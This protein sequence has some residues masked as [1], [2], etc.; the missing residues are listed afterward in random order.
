MRCTKCGAELTPGM[1]FCS[2]CGTKVEAQ[3]I[4]KVRFCM[5]CGASIE[6]GQKCCP[7]CGAKIDPYGIMQSSEDN[8]NKTAP[9]KDASDS[10]E[11]E[12]VS[13]NTADLTKRPDTKKEKYGNTKTYGNHQKESITTKA[14][15][16]PHKREGKDGAK[17]KR[18][19]KGLS[20]F[21]KVILV[22][23]AVV[24]V[25]LI[26]ASMMKQPPMIALNIAAL[27]G[28]ILSF[29]IHKGLLLKDKKWLQYI[30]YGVSVFLVVL[31]PGMISSLDTSSEE[32]SSE[33]SEK[34][35]LPEHQLY[36]DITSA[37]NWIFS[38][39][40]MKIYVDGEEIGTVA[41][42]AE[43]T[44]LL[45]VTEGDHEIS[46]YD[47]E[48]TNINAA[49]DIKVNGDMTFAA[50]LTHDS[51]SIAFTK[52][53]NT[54]GVEGSAL[55]VPDVTGMVLQDAMTQLANAGFS[56]VREEPYSEIW[57][58][59]NWIVISESPEAGNTVDK[60][61]QIILNCKHIDED[62]AA[63]VSSSEAA[64][65][66]TKE[67]SQKE[68]TQEET[69]AQTVTTEKNDAGKASS[70]GSTQESGESTTETKDSSSKTS[71]AGASAVPAKKTAHV[72]KLTGLQYTLAVAS[73]GKE[74]SNY[75]LFDT[76]DHL[77]T[78]FSTIDNGAVNWRYEGS[79]SSDLI[80]HCY[81][82]GS[83]YWDWHMSYPDKS[84]HSLVK[85]YDTNNFDWDYNKVDL[86]KAIKELD[87]LEF[88]DNWY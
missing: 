32:A 36:L 39:Y 84:D 70:A 46:A 50:T 83:D 31:S 24:A 38:T 74:S 35:V 22:T 11:T 16:E 80:I 37:D 47:A 14:N 57:V 86:D 13:N 29:L 3:E 49:N 27:V 8:N 62:A 23:I 72:S 5:N 21:A 45:T 25:F 60:A 1:K 71:S 59:E 18:N 76:K 54:E 64:D 12:N 4:K 65:T 87:K 44:Q 19:I 68:A 56:N 73:F 43:F 81:D 79:L 6:E 52:I 17:S 55:V 10:P 66:S 78:Y 85:L 7:E 61:T 15:I 41:D 28:L 75:Y 33:Q 51:S 30:I 88:V 40:D 53:S 63:S 77:I 69:Q 48:N 20:V 42:G 58:R 9:S 67:D 82:G 26:A 2:N 34:V